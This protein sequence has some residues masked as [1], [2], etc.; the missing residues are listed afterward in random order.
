VL[1]RRHDHAAAVD[2]AHRYACPMHPEVGS[3]KPD[4]ECPICHMVLERIAGPRAGTP[5]PVT[6][7]AKKRTFTKPARGPAWVSADGA[8]EA[9]FPKGDLV[10]VASGDDGQ[11]FRAAAPT[12]A[13]G[14]HLAA[15]PPVAWDGTT[16]KVRFRLPPRAKAEPGETGWVTLGPR[17]RD[18][19]VV[20][21]SAVLQ[22][23]Q[24][25]Y[26]LAPSTKGDVFTRRPVEI[27][28]VLH[29]VAVVLSGL[30]E[31]DRVVAGDAFFLEARQ[32]LEGGS[33][34][35]PPVTP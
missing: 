7:T 22:S 27:G 23:P 5:A 14:V 32:R 4:D 13:F 12:V 15:E 29:G 30:G 2:G 1:A 35:V 19:L 34:N 21:S 16:A 11:F 33:E 24:G 26:V 18:Y 8:V 28:K 25:P 10:G 9:I 3:A 31:G 17:P 20:P 6:D